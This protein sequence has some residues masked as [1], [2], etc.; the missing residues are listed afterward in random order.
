MSFRLEKDGLSAFTVKYKALLLDY[1][2]VLSS[3]GRQGDGLDRLLSHL[4]V[5]PRDEYRESTWPLLDLFKV[6]KLSNQEFWNRLAKLHDKDVPKDIEQIWKVEFPEHKALI[7]FIKQKQSTGIITAILSNVWP[8]TRQHLLDLGAYD[9]YD[10][11]FLS[12]ELGMAKP[13]PK[14]FKYALDKMGVAA[15]DT[16]FVDDQEKNTKAAEKL[17]MAVVLAKNEAQIIKDLSALLEDQE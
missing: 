10:H 17:G 5:E 1:G 16:I 14:I 4:G 2:G 12:D 15:E 3:F 13:D 6:G 7:S 8:P 9:G 11:V